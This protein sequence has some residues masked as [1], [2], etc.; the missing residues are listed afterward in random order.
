[1]AAFG[2]EMRRL[3]A[4]QGLSLRRLASLTAYDVGYLS[5]VR[6]GRKPATRELAAR[7]DDALGAQGMLLAMASLPGREGHADARSVVPAEPFGP[8]AVRAVSR[9][10]YQD[11]IL[12]PG[13]EA[14]LTGLWPGNCGSQH[15]ISTL[16]HGSVT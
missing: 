14:D 2:A 13:A 16:P 12:R 1:M 5:K 9:A 6:N 11:G 3:M 15:A 10:F 4:E 8:S 7:V